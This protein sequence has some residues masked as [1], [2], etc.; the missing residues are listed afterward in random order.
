MSI[1][2]TFLQKKKMRESHYGI[3]MVA[4]AYVLSFLLLVLGSDAFYNSRSRAAGIN[5]STDEVAQEIINND[6]NNDTTNDTNNEILNSEIVSYD[7]ALTGQARN[8]QSFN[9]GILSS[10]TSTN[11]LV[12][13]SQMSLNTQTTQT[14]LVNP[15]GLA[16]ITEEDFPDE[17][18]LNITMTGDTNWLLGYP[19]DASEYNRIMDQMNG[20]V[21]LIASHQAPEAEKNTIESFSVE[22][23]TNSSFMSVT[24]EEVQMLER[25]VEA[26]A[27]GE[28][29]IGKILIVNVILNRMSDEDFPDSI[30]G[31]IFQRVEGDYQFSPIKD[32]RFWEVNVTKK[33][34]TAVQRAL[35]GE[36]Y[37][38]GA[39]YFMARK[40]TK[41][42]NAKWFD[43][44][45]ER[46]F[47]H[48]GHEF[49]K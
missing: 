30:E 26:E 7:Q 5:N 27:T 17:Q 9:A 41:S 23:K 4:V 15:Y 10:N 45:L 43:Q 18:T 3:F 31:V 35:D 20:F 25:I 21:N 38:E 39:L 8:N 40:N 13:T 44:H 33:T 46:L 48:G 36:D 37:S 24:D 32:Q 49:Y 28:D 34:R 19:M 6:T 22:A 47:K 1:I 14:K 11:E 42:S 2:N 29:M 12:N 16:E